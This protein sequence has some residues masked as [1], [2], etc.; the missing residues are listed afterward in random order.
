MVAH[1]R[2][3]LLFLVLA[4]AVGLCGCSGAADPV[5]PSSTA[6]S[7]PARRAKTVGLTGAVSDL[8]L[9]PPPFSLATRG[10]PRL[11]TNRRRHVRLES[12]ERHSRCD[13]RH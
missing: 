1:T 10:G 2:I 11:V 13:S 3:A 12:G 4:A 6:R 5:S 9:A 8:N 7:Q